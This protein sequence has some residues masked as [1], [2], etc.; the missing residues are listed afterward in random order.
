MAAA[1]G[2]RAWL[3]LGSFF[4]LLS[5]GWFLSRLF[6]V[7]IDTSVTERDAVAAGPPNILLL[8]ADDLGYNDT[9]AFGATGIETPALEDIA[10][11]GV[12]FRRHYAHA[13]CTPSRVALLTGRHAE[14]FG[15]RHD[16]MEIP[17]EIVTLPEAL[18]SNGYSTHLVG[19]WHAGEMR[20]QSLPLA[21]GFDSYFGFHNQWALAAQLPRGEY[22]YVKPTYINPLLREGHAE[23]TKHQGHLTDILGERTQAIIKSGMRADSPWFIYHGFLA[24]HAPIEPAQRYAKQFPD[25]PEGR[26]RA[27][28]RHLDDTVAGFMRTLEETG[29]A[30]NTVVIFVSDNGGTNLERDNNYPFFGRKNET[31]EGSVRTP[32]LMRLPKLQAAGE[33]INAVVMNTDIYPTVMAL[34][35]AQVTDR[36]DGSNLMPLLHG[37]SI[38]ERLLSWEQYHWNINALSYTVLDETGRWRL[39]SMYGLTPALYD[40]QGDM[41]GRTDV[42]STHTENTNALQIKYRER[43]WA[44]SQ[45]YP[46]EVKRGEKTLYTGWDMQRTPLHHGFSLGLAFSKQQLADDAGTVLAQQKDLWTLTLDAGREIRL[47]IG[48]QQLDGGYLD[49]RA[50]QEIV[51]TGNYQPAARVAAIAEAYRLKL[52]VNGQLRDILKTV[53]KN[54]PRLA[55]AHHATEIWHGGRAVFSNAS[56]ST[57]REIY[58]PER[59]PEEHRALFAASYQRDEL[60]YP[61]MEYLSRN[62]CGEN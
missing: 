47:K 31:Y 46:R 17:L 30:D 45:F 51:I 13:T 57:A 23:P 41:R 54:Y 25:T 60:E 33:V 43:Q 7:E 1:L 36:L 44:L 59:L 48:D 40:L 8:V 42:A 15:F 32:L 29:Q 52:Y 35:G 26:Y 18:R 38:G 55:R 22:A 9:S 12:S 62:L 39:S 16:G 3:L 58:Y 2:G 49:D 50:C 20:E 56:V 14:R 6:G 28:V 5:L 53:P 24:P 27:L 37:G 61:R 34:A 21:Q 4:L 10:Q 19:K 11:Q